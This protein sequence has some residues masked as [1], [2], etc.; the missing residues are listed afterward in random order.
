M[1]QLKTG[2]KELKVLSYRTKITICKP[3]EVVWQL[4][5][6]EYSEV[7]KY[8]NGIFESGSYGSIADGQLG[9]SRICYLNKSKSMFMREMIESMNSDNMEFTNKIT[10]TKKIPI[11][12][13]VSKT[14]VKVIPIDEFS[15][16]IESY[17]EYQTSPYFLGVLMKRIFKSTM[18]DFLISINHFLTKNEIVYAENFKRIKKEWKNRS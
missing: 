15:C 7:S 2:T 12:P 4:L 18:M 1:T 8:A 9:C 13:N 14:T 11:I 16:Q 17:S 6:G 10:A 3:A 5:L